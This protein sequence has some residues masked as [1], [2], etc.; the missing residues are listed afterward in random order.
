MTDPSHTRLHA[1]TGEE[2]GLELLRAVR[3]MKSGVAARTTVVEPNV[4]AAARARIRANVPRPRAAE[5]PKHA[6]ES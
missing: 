1:P 4:V 6:D 5:A 3:E 2:L